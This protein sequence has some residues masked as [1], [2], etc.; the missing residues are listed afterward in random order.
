MTHR[1]LVVDDEPGFQQLV[2]EI[3]SDRGYEARSTGNSHRALQMLEVFQPDVLLSDHLLGGELDGFSLLRR[4]RELRADL[5]CI[6][7]TGYAE[8]ELEERLCQLDRFHFV[9]K[10]FTAEEIL[11]CVEDSLS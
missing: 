6:L 2:R 8:P 11:R 1:I 9:E 5:R 3:L 7:M 4:A 10:P